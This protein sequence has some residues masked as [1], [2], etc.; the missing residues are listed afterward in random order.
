[1]IKPIKLLDLL[2]V[3]SVTIIAGT[4]THFSM[5]SSQNELLPIC[6]YLATISGTFLNN[7]LNPANKLM[8]KATIETLE[9]TES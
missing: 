6:S 7:T 1:M 5:L 2:E 8:L 4:N 9:K 3:G